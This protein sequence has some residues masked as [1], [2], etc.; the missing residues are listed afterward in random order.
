MTND[1]GLTFSVGDT[2]LWF[3]IVLSKTIKIG[4]VNYHV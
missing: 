1:V 2:L 4:D 3:T